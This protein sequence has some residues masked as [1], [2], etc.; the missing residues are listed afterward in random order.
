M[1]EIYETGLWRQH[2]D[3]LL[4]EAEH[5]RLVRQ[6]KEARRK[7]KTGLREA[8]LRRLQGGATGGLRTGDEPCA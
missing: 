7:E 5:G 3:D 2:R 6:L 4:R 1:H 8:L